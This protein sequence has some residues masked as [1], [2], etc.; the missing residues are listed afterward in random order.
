MKKQTV[1]R[2]N[3]NLTKIELTVIEELLKNQEQLNESMGNPPWTKNN[4]SD[5]IRFAICQLGYEEGLGDKM[6]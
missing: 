2:I 6:Q 4:A 3:V 1:K 5:I